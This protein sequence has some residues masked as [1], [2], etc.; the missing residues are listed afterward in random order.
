MIVAAEADNGHDGIEMI[1]R[2]QPDVVLMDVNMPILNGV[3]ATRHV[4]PAYPRV[5]IIGL[6]MQDDAS[7]IERMRAAGAVAFLSKAEA[8]EKLIDVIRAVSS[9]KAGNGVSGPTGA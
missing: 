5:S 6:S 3:E 9:V 8:G 1:K 7:V 2:V 4:A